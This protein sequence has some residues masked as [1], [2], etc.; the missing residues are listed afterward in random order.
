MDDVRSHSME[1][2][3]WKSFPPRLATGTALVG[4]S[5]AI[6][7]GMLVENEPIVILLRAMVAMII[8]WALAWCAGSMIVLA[9]SRD[10]TEAPSHEELSEQED[11]SAVDVE[12][13]DSITA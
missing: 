12:A 13:P 11:T 4:F 7:N 1:V 5:V 3:N 2:L 9:V 6:L 8:C 10:G